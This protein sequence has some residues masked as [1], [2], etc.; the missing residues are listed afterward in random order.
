[1]EPVCIEDWEDLAKRRLAPEVYDFIAGGAGRERT[2]KE[3]IN[4][5]SQIRLISRVLRGVSKV[6]ISAPRLSPVQHGRTPA[7]PLIIAPSA[8]HQLVHPDG[9]LATLAAANQCGA[10]LA[11][12]T[13]SDTPL[14]TVCKQSTAPVMFQLYLYKDRARN[15]DI[16]QQA[17]DA[18]CSALMLTVDVPRMGARLRDRRNEF[19]VNR[20]R[21]SADRSG[22]QPLIQPH[23]SG[24]S[25][26]AAFVAEHLEPAISWTDV[27]WV[28]SQTRMPL[29]LKG[30]L[31][32]QDAEIAQKHEVDAL[33]LSNHGGRQLDHHV[34]AIDMLPHIRQRL[35]AAMPLIVDGGIRSGADILKAL[36]LGADAV[37]VGRPALWGLAAA[38]AQGVAAVLRQLIDDLILSMHICGCAS[39][40][41]I[42][43]EIICT[44]HPSYQGDPL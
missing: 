23:N 13:M 40:A 17:Q 12:S 8:H 5:L 31:H 20:Y 24:R 14:E 32:P 1:M 42:N 22:E 15:R 3:N 30:V 38:G 25:R 26:V 36:A 16:I 33:Y 41:D 37:G 29:I 7:T 21:K 28:K 11:L 34:S 43:Q 9:E 6:D 27:A 35:G 18:G 44:K 2:L 19:D 4:A 39:L 10:P